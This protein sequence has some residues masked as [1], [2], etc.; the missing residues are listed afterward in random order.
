VFLEGTKE[1]ESVCDKRPLSNQ[2]EHLV[3]DVLKQ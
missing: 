2:I 3:V 1:V